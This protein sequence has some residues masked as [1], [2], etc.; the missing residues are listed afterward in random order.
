MHVYKLNLNPQIRELHYF[1]CDFD[2][3]SFVRHFSCEEIQEDNQLFRRA[4]Q[5]IRFVN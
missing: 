1:Y 3:K 2:S 4:Q 5:E